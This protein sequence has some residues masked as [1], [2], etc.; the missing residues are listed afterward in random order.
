MDPIVVIGTGLGT[1]LLIVP[2]AN[3][4][5]YVGGAFTTYKGVARES[6]RAA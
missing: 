4:D 5:L 1:V 6:H 3:G 2:S